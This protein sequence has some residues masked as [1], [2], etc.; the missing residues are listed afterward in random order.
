MTTAVTIH[1]SFRLIEEKK[2]NFNNKMVTRAYLVQPE[3]V[4]PPSV[5]D[6]EDTLG[7]IVPNKD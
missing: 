7:S 4:S 2:K 3:T 5:S 1:V 6:K